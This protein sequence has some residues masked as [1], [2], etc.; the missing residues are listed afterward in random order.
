MA[1][2][3]GDVDQERESRPNTSNGAAMDVDD[4]IVD[5]G[6]SGDEDRGESD[7]A[8][9]NKLRREC[10]ALRVDCAVAQKIEERAERE[11]KNMR[12]AH[13]GLVATAAKERQ[14]RESFQ[15]RW[16]LTCREADH[17]RGRVRQL[18]SRL[19]ESEGRVR[20]LESQL[21]ESEGRGHGD[22][23]RK[24]ARARS[25]SPD[26]DHLSVNCYG[27]FQASE[28]RTDGNQQVATVPESVTTGEDVPMSPPPAPA[29]QNEPTAPS[30][31]P[32]PSRTREG[33]DFTS[34]DICSAIKLENDGFPR[35]VAN[36]RVAHDLIHEHRPYVLA[37]RLWYLRVYCGK[38]PPRQRTAVQRVAVDEYIQPDWF[39]YTIQA[40]AAVEKEQNRRHQF[41]HAKRSQIGY[42]PYKYGE[43][44]QFR[45]DE[46]RGLKFVDEFK[47]LNRRQVRGANLFEA[48]GF[49]RQNG[50]NTSAPTN[51]M[52]QRR[53][54]LD[55]HILTVFAVEGLYADELVRQDIAVNDAFTPEYWPM[56][57]NTE[58]T[59][60]TVCRRMAAMGVSV[61]RIDD[62]FL[63]VH[64]FAFATDALPY[65]FTEPEI[66][67]L[68]ALLQ[69]RAIPSSL[70]P[71]E[72]PLF[73]WSPFTPSLNETVNAVM[74]ELSH[75]IEPEV[76]VIRRPASSVI[77]ADLARG[78][79]AF[80]VNR[81]VVAHRNPY[82]IRT[83]PQMNSSAQ[84]STPA[85]DG[86]SVPPPRTTIP[87]PPCSYIPN[88]NRGYS[89]RS[90]GN[91]VRR[92]T[93]SARAVA[94]P[95]HSPLLTLHAPIITPVTA[96]EAI[97]V[98][99]TTGDR[100]LNSS[101]HAPE[102]TQDT[103]MTPAPIIPTATSTP[104]LASVT[105]V[106]IAPTA[107]STTAVSPPITSGM[108]TNETL[109]AERAALLAPPEQLDFS[110]MGALGTILLFGQ[111]PAV[112]P[113]ESGYNDFMAQME[114]PP[115]E[116]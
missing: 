18:E 71:G 60:A 101:I 1:D 46:L 30:F 43:I 36:W 31:V 105:T 53:A 62:A 27:T 77:A 17:L 3:S 7:N 61:A 10:A 20:Q 89:P 41:Q 28:R 76:G 90:R 2:S 50:K 26:L 115:K 24:R 11:L 55:K 54:L 113:A 19:D 23:S 91:T 16:S 111:V 4:D 87:T 65:D 44:V 74:T 8:V 70:Y 81:G 64:A 56:S 107:A 84:S 33:F 38:I 116:E 86:T 37:L 66:A 35:D 109:A 82:R 29:P 49:E 102:Q 9:I 114:Q 75:P 39:A 57:D 48:L 110:T 14:A 85:S 72:E 83:Y 47:T 15:E 73:A 96:P 45:S 92:P 98:D 97:A 106:T 6:D 95:V 34:P 78:C 12:K 51:A 40:A 108:A 21:D 103:V 88:A 104:P 13:D 52:R 94:V 68:R 32:T 93:T 100:T 63:F 22:D 80:G 5:Y 42:N 59:I 25:A 79:Y 67:A 112:V 99:T 69:S 58:L